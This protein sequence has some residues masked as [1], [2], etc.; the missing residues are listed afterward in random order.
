M[1]IK[2]EYFTMES[3]YEPQSLVDKIDAE[4][5]YIVL[6]PG[7]PSLDLHLNIC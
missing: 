1:A 7:K 2:Q 3:P 6:E 5:I 4:A